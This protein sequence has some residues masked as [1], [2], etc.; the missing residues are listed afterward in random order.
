VNEWMIVWLIVK[1]VGRWESVIE[2]DPLTENNHCP[3]LS[4]FPSVIILTLKQLQFVNCVQCDVSAVMGRVMQEP[5][6]SVILV[7]CNEI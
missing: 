4:T 6:T 2:T 7:C 5:V 1:W 3:I